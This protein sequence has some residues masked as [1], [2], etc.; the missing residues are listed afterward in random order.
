MMD[1]YLEESYQAWKGRQR[2][3]GDVVKKKRR[4][5]N[6]E[7]ELTC[8][9]GGGGQ[10]GLLHCDP[11]GQLSLPPLAADS[12]AG[13]AAC[14]C[15]CREDEVEEDEHRPQVPSSES[16]SEQ[17]AEE[18]AEEV[19]LRLPNTCFLA[20]LAPCCPPAGHPS[21][22]RPLTTQRTHPPRTRMPPPLGRAAA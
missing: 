3:K 1:E 18:E 9:W 6:D 2:I 4:R 15:V 16:E 14:R 5:L 20:G 10:G 7:G 21:C 22:K 12:P 11:K 17:E 13:P 8:G 19:G